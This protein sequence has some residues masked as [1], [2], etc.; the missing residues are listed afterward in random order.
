MT[1]IE[2]TEE[3]W[4]PVTGCSKVSEGC[5][6]CYAESLSHRF[7]WTTKPWTAQNADENV[8]MHPDRLD[9]PV[10]IRKP[11]M[12]F[13]NSMSDLFHVN[14]T[15]EFITQVF[16]VMLKTPRHTYQI[17][18]KRPDRMAS[19]VT[20]Y[21][22]KKGLDK[23]PQNIWLGTSVEDSRVMNRIDLIRDIK[24]HILFLSC[25]PLIGSLPNMNLKNISWIIVGAESGDSHVRVMDCDWVRYIR[26]QCIKSGTKFFFKQKAVNGRK[27]SLPVLDGKAW[28]EMPNVMGEEELVLF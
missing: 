11:T 22:N 12:W 19:F 14:V 21:L 10:K 1:K 27:I 2:W 3:S 15:I 25:E 8:K 24:A 7:G 20:L 13:V 18:T 23:L 17:L 4:N 6:N 16:D 5:R 28:K 26:D 9:K